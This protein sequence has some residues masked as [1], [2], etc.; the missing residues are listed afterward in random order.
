VRI[1]SVAVEKALTPLKQSERVTL[2]VL[3]LIMTACVLSSEK[4]DFLEAAVPNSLLCLLLHLLGKG[5][6][7]RFRTFVPL[8]KR[9]FLEF[10][11]KKYGASVIVAWKSE[12]SRS[13]VSSTVS[14]SVKS[15]KEA[16]NARKI[17]L[18][19]EIEKN[20][21]LFINNSVIE[22]DE[23]TTPV[24]GASVDVGEVSELF[25]NGTCIICAGMI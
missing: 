24:S 17:R 23:D 14:E 8:L 6:D 16:A 25:K 12:M 11:V 1:V 4:H 13:V 10:E 2:S 18:K 21:A 7:E 22:V 19:I 15:R 3:R 5:G 20:Q 9:I